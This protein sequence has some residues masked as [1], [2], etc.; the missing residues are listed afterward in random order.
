MGFQH[1]NKR[2]LTWHSND[3]HMAS[4]NDYILVISRF[5]SLVHD[6]STMCGA[7]TGNAYGSDHVLARTCLKVQLSSA[8]KMLCARCL[9][10]SKIRQPGTAKILDKEIPSCFTTLTNVD[11][12]SEWSAL[13]ALVDGAAEKILGYTQQRRS[14]WISGRTLQLSAC[15]ARVWSNNDVSLRQLRKMMAKSAW[16]DRKKYRAE[17]VSQWSRPQT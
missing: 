4:Q 10:V 11:G 13:K 9:D 12:S 3:D 5:R 7:K 16:E 6:S 15:S 2:P 14:D 17:K 8:P 1:Q